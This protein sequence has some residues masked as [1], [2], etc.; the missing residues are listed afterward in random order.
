[1]NIFNK[2]DL[3]YDKNNQVKPVIKECIYELFERFWVL[4]EN[5]EKL[6]YQI[7]DNE[8][9]L[10]RFFRDTFRYR[11][12]SNHEMIK[13]EK[14]PVKPLSWMGEKYI[15]SVPV[16][17]SAKDFAFFFRILAFLE[18]KSVDQQFTLKNIC[19]AISAF[20]QE[21]VVW[22]EGIGYQNR[23]SLVRLLKYMVKMSLIKVIDQEI[24]DFTGNDNHDVLLERTPHSSYFMRMFPQEEVE[25]WKGLRDF[26]RYMERENQEI[27]DRKHRYYRRLFLEPVV[28]HN[29]LSEEERD[30]IKKFYVGVENT[31]YRYT[32]LTYERYKSSSLVVKT[33]YVKGEKIYPADNMITKIAILMGNYLYTRPLAFPKNERNEIE[34]MGE[35]IAT[36]LSNLRKEYKGSWTKKMKD[37]KLEE[38]QKEV[39]SEL[40]MWGFLEEKSENIYVIK[41]GIFRFVG[42]YFK[43]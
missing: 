18:G 16:F 23:L 42:D 11:L 2:V 40:V 28:Y 38:L 24:E 37:Y 9:E 30:Y 29:E 6:F 34:L 4:R 13:L 5:D 32:D 35:E 12:V 21:Q 41:E 8:H 31:I 25:N 19:D 14:I 27:A 1:M 20:S 36:V 22:K 15:N 39:M 26:L 10:K 43:D 3:E 17:K 33:D 7:K